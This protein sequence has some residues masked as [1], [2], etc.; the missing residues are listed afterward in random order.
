MMH[1]LMI[2][3][4]DGYV[5]GPALSTAEV[6]TRYILAP[7][8]LFTVIAVIVF[9]LTSERKPKERASSVITHIE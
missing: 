5:P 8:L 1:F 7:T 2:A 9:A 4:E 6:V 3:Q